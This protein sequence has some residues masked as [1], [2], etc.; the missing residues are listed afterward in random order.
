MPSS[1]T[2]ESTPV[3]RHLLWGTHF[4]SHP[5]LCFPGVHKACWGDG[6]Q[7]IQWCVARIHL[8]IPRNPSPT[9]RHWSLRITARVPFQGLPSAT[10]RCLSHPMTVLKEE[11]SLAFHL[12]SGHL[13]R[14]TPTSELLLGSAEVSPRTSSS[15]LNFSLCPLLLPLL[16]EDTPSKHPQ[17]L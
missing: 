3:D 5:G 4:H 13:G 1:S 17:S 9:A 10:R 6:R 7:R 11:Q 8:Q 2:E 16:P 14:A 15:R 12:H